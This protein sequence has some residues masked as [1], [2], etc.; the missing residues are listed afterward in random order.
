MTPAV[1]ARGS[2]DASRSASAAPDGSAGR[3]VSGVNKRLTL[4]ATILGSSIAILDGSVVSVALPSIQRSLGGG[5]AGQQWVSNAYLLTLGSLIL[6][7][8]S[9]GDIF[10]E[11]RVFALGV[12]GFGAASVLCALAPTIGL[13][14]AFRALQGVAGA[15]LT[16][17]SLAVIVSTFPERERGPAIGTWT[18]WG[19]I[20]G[21]LGPLVAGGILAIGS[22]RWIFV[23]NL[24]LV[25]ACLWLITRA[26]PATSPTATH[27]RVD[28][29]GAVLC[30]LG[31]G[32]TVFALIEQPRLGWSNP[33]V[34][35]SLIGGVTLF[36]AFVAYE[37]RA[38]DPMLRLDLFKSRNFAVGNVET[39]ALYGG[40][41]ALFFFLILYLQQVAGYSPLK[42]GLALL[43]ESVVMFAL[44]SRFGALADRLGPRWFMGG[45]PLVAGAGMLMLLTFGVHVDYLTE[46]LPGILVFSVGLSVTVAPLTAAILAGIDQAEAGIGSAVNN[47][48]A[49]V[50]GLIATVAIGAIVAAQFSSSLDHHLA[51][52][53][54]TPSGQAAVVEAKQL[55]LGRPS[56]VGVPPREATAIT[57]ASGQSSLDAFRVGI[58]VASGLVVLGGL[59]GAAGIQNPRRTV[60]AQQCAGGQLAGAP[61]DAAG[62]HATAP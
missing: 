25:V 49:R 38:R 39:L 31:L 43:P 9:L 3:E 11:R 29:I 7:G 58:D 55:T 32:G 37:S 12:A 27:R 45:G 36:V 61:L 53:P 4:V 30:M 48:V 10:G 57:A 14:V 35:G 50:A 16:P 56:V 6:L 40:L 21:A 26:V 33:A 52:Q 62:L 1:P 5:L 47:A 8:G 44:S 15:L 23:I 19:T 2:P 28:V 46:V 41:S 13:L 59:I 18:A 60:R 51:G 17:S 20:A 24:P 34:A 54:L 22:W 42:S